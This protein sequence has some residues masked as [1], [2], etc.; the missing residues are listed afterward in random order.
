MI[1][2]NANNVLRTTD[3]FLSQEEVAR[4]TGFKQK[5]KQVQQLIRMRIPHELDSWEYPI[6]LRRTVENRLD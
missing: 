2:L 6:I 3:F 5:K 1:P 4:L